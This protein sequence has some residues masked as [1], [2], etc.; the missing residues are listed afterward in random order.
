M[1]LIRVTLIFAV[2]FG[3][4]AFLAL[5]Y[6]SAFSDSI[7]IMGALT[8]G[9]LFFGGAKSLLLIPLLLAAGLALY[10]KGRGAVRI[11]G[12]ILFAPLAG[13]V[14]SF[15]TLQSIQATQNKLAVSLAPT[16]YKQFAAPAFAKDERILVSTSPMRAM[17]LLAN[18]HIDEYYQFNEMEI[19]ERGARRM[20]LATIGECDPNHIE[21]QK[22]AFEAAGRGGE[23]ILIEEG[24]ALP[25]N[26]LAILSRRSGVV[27]E[28]WKDG[29]T[30]EQSEWPVII[31]PSIY[32]DG[33]DHQCGP[34]L[35]RPESVLYGVDQYTYISA[36]DPARTN[37]I[38]DLHARTLYALNRRSSALLIN[39]WQTTAALPDRSAIG[40][41]RER[42]I[43]FAAINAST[44]CR[45]NWFRTSNVVE[46]RAKEKIANLVAALDD[47]GFRDVADQLIALL[48]SPQY[49]E[50]CYSFGAHF[51]AQR[52]QINA[53][54]YEPAAWSIIGSPGVGIWQLEGAYAVFANQLRKPNEQRLL[55]MQA[56]D[57]AIALDPKNAGDRIIAMCRALSGSGFDDD[58]RIVLAEHVENMTD[59]QF[60]LYL[61][62]T[63]CL[64]KKYSRKGDAPNAADREVYERIKRR[65]G[66]YDGKNA[67][68]AIQY[69]ATEAGM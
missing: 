64:H 3:A 58:I 48:G 59:D 44:A 42:Q 50:S 2:I 30:T 39:V 35:P 15:L 38:D 33:N 67:A 16:D 65:A 18:G 4:T 32:H 56:V 25:L 21:H 45:K 12:I 46:S 5:R 57:Q 8:L 7:I 43:K 22:A 60:K 53:S 66:R 61:D 62:T 13:I 47:P 37:I 27:F 28:L 54:R 24:V 10:V 20:T 41:K 52:M 68:Y 51:I 69:H 19:G 36:T 1:L 11:I 23:C 14:I 55:H 26:A 9:V 40:D 6:D 29:K 31:C 34:I 17:Q 63:V 49:A